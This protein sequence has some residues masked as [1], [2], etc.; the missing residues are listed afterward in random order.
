MGNSPSTV[1]ATELRQQP[2]CFGYLALLPGLRW[3]SSLVVAVEQQDRS[4]PME[5]DE[6]SQQDRACV[7][8]VPRRPIP[9]HAGDL[10]GVVADAE[11]VKATAQRLEPLGTDQVD[12]S[13][14]E[15]ALDAFV[16]GDELEVRETIDEALKR[17]GAVLPLEGAGRPWVG[18]MWHVMPTRQ[19]LS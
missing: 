4:L 6:D 1:K 9:E 2:P 14:R 15:D 7:R 10:I 19:S 18:C 3:I 8:D 5:V 12:P 16:E 17:N 13:R 11:F